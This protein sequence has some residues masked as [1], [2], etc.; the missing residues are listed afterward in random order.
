MKTNLL[1]DFNKQVSLG[2]ALNNLLY[3]FIYSLDSKIAIPN[4]A[5]NVMKAFFNG[6]LDKN[7]RNIFQVLLSKLASH[8]TFK[9]KK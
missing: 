8:F 7:V 3:R 9:I 5:I 1:V 6:S 4:R 2:V